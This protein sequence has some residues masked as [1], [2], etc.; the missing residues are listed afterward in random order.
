MTK[1][2]A[3]ERLNIIVANSIGEFEIIARV[4]ENYGKSRT[5]FEIRSG[6]QCKKYGYIDNETGK[7]VPE[8]YGNLEDNYTFSGAVFEIEEEE[9]ETKRFTVENQVDNARQYAGEEPHAEIRENYVGDYIEATSEEEAIDLAIDYIMEHIQST[10][11]RVGNEILVYDNGEV[12]EHYYNFT[13]T[14][15]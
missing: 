3:I 6:K 15:K 12:I 10:K 1:E 14:E 9:M 8:K 2:Y 4:W 5:Y 11:E 13:A 7:Y